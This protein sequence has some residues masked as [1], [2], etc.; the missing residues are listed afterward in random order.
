MKT[1]FILDL[2]SKRLKEINIDD[3]SSINN[4]LLNDDVLFDK[5]V[6][7]IKNIK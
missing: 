7:L 2:K 1:V 5:I 3:F 4:S 6:K